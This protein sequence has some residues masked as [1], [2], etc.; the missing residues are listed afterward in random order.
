M[1]YPAQANVMQRR[2]I[3]F[4]Y[5]SS[6]GN[7]TPAD[8][9]NN[10]LSRISSMSTN[11]LAP[12]SGNNIADFD[13]SGTGRRVR[14]SMGAGRIVRDSR[15]N[16]TDVG[17]TNLDHFGRMKDF[18]FRGGVAGSSGFNTVQYR[19]QYGYD[20]VGNRTSSKI[21]ERIGNNVLTD[22]AD[23]VES[24]YDALNRLTGTKTGTLDGNGHATGVLKHT[25]T[26]KLDLL[27]N[28]VGDANHPGR[29]STRDIGNNAVETRSSTHAVNER[30]ELTFVDFAA[31]NAAN[32]PPPVD[33][34]TIYDQSGNLVYDGIYFYQY[35]AWGR[36]IQVNQTTSLLEAPSSAPA[37]SPCPE[38]PFTI[39]AMIKHFTYDGLGRLVRVQS[40][41]PDSDNA[42]GGVR[43]ERFYYDGA[44]RIQELVTDP[45]ATIELL[46]TPEGAGNNPE[47]N[48]LMNQTVPGEILGSG[49]GSANPMNLESGL[50][51][52]PSTVIGSG[53]TP[54]P[55]SL[56]GL[57]RE[58]VWGPGDNGL[59]EILVQ[60]D[61]ERKP[62]WMIQD[63]GGDV[64]AMCDLAGS[65]GT[66][67]VLRSWQYDAYGQCLR[68]TDVVTSTSGYSIPLNRIGH[69][70][71]FMDRL[72]KGLADPTTHA[73]I[74]RLEPLSSVLYQNRNRTYS[75]QFGRFIQRDPNETGQSTTDTACLCSALENM[76]RENERI[77]LV[78]MSNVLPG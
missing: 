74:P 38:G 67:R 26:W 14:Q 3:G 39:G 24:L 36:L 73:D 30:N 52:N 72:D 32:P 33:T 9:I 55:T 69:K 34:T 12:Y 23:S 35:D 75:P 58:Y 37:P 65:G 20:E 21:S 2:E 61:S 7:A 48:E 28:W 56:S 13:W 46:E 57:E 47:L 40:P 63:G 54:L 43:S 15:A 45:I 78:R 62:F 70:G 11:L 19:A 76:T 8:I 51:E 60:Y 5:G 29:E 16:S 68:A 4:T 18:A 41:W 66:A 44:R 25:D 31:E 77:G 64:V 1:T 50:L 6:S 42:S 59:D 53:G 71:L 10:K 27:G 22:N 17:F 49:D